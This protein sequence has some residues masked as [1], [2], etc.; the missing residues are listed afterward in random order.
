MHYNNGDVM[1]GNKMETAAVAR[2]DATVQNESERIAT[3][4]ERS[5]HAA[6]KAELQKSLLLL[7]TALLATLGGLTVHLHNA[8]INEIAQI[9]EVM[10]ELLQRLPGG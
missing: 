10:F 4:E 2:K 6:T 8:T 7:F 1:E 3:L 5:K 9:R